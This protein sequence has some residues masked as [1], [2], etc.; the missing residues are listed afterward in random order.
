MVV[1]AELVQ[2]SDLFQDSG[3][4]Y[5]MIQVLVLPYENDS[6]KMIQV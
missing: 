5:K 6:G 2:S 4:P 1:P 3:L